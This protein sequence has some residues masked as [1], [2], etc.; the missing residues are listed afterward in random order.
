VVL[1]TGTS[2]GIGRA[3][4]LAFARAGATPVVDGGMTLHTAFRDNG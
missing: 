4:A 1:L 2:S 3:T